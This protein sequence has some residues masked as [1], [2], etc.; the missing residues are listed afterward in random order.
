VQGEGEQTRYQLAQMQRGSAIVLSLGI[1][2]RLN[3]VLRFG[4]SLG[5]V[6]DNDDT[7]FTFAAARSVDE[8]LMERTTDSMSLNSVANYSRV[9]I[10]AT[11]GMR[12]VPNDR[13]RVALSLTTPGLAFAGVVAETES[14]AIFTSRP[15]VPVGDHQ[16]TETDDF[17]FR[18]GV[19]SPLRVRLG[20]AAR[21]Q[22]T[23]LTLDGDLQAPVRDDSY[24]V[25]RDLVLNARV[26]VRVSTSPTLSFGGGVFTDRSGVAATSSATNG[27][28]E[29]RDF[30]GM[31][32]GIEHVKVRRLAEGE[33]TAALRFVSTYA[34]R[35]AFAVG[36]VNGVLV[37]PSFDARTLGA[38]ETNRVRAVTHDLGLYIGSSLRF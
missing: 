15:D 11:V 14:T 24:G 35:Y 20:L 7:N 30:Y 12:Y 38:I 23:V 3:D 28:T 27:S 33:D 37:D 16:L 31:T 29:N 25:R 6:Y 4:I 36:H 5:I 13:F 18:T 21:V 10:R 34:L 9:G 1:G 8:P 32:L 2:H 26:G 19:F 22:G 17:A